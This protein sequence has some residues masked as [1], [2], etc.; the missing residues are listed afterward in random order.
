MALNEVVN[1]FKYYGDPTRSRS[2]FNGSLYIGEPDLDPKIPANQKTVTARQEDGTEVAI[3]QPIA[4]NSG[5]YP[6]FNGSVVMLLV[7]GS[8]SMRLDDSQDNLVYEEALVVASLDSGSGITRVDTVADLRLFEPVTEGQII[9]LL[10][11]TNAGTGGGEFFFDESDASTADNNGTV[12]VTPAGARWKRYNIESLNIEFFGAITGNDSQTAIS[13][14]VDEADV[15]GLPVLIPTG[16]FIKT[17]NKTLPSGVKMIGSEGSFLESDSF[18]VFNLEADCGIDGVGFTNTENVLICLQPL[19]DN[20]TVSRCDFSGGSQIVLV[21]TADFVTVDGCTF[22]GCGFQI[23]QRIGFTSNFGTVSNCTSID[24]V[25]DFVELNSEDANPS[26]NWTV[27]GNRV[28]N[29]GPSGEIATESR[30]LGSTAT[31]NLIISNNIIENTSGDSMIHLEGTSRNT[32]IDG[33]VFVNPHGA[34]GSLI[35]VV[36][37][38]DIPQLLNF[39]NNSVQLN[40]SYVDFTGES[41]TLIYGQGGDAVDWNVSGNTFV[42]DSA[43][44]KTVINLGSSENI[45]FK[46]NRIEGFDTCVVLGTGNFNIAN[47]E[48]NFFS[49]NTTTCISAGGNGDPYVVNITNNEFVDSVEVFIG[50]DNELINSLNTN[51]IGD[52][53][54]I[55]EARVIGDFGNNSLVFNN[56]LIDSGTTSASDTFTALDSVQTKLFT[57]EGSNAFK[58]YLVKVKSALGTIGNGSSTAKVVLVNVNSPL[59]V[60]IVELSSSSSGLT[61]P[62]ILSMDGLTLT[63][64]PSE[65]MVTRLQFLNT[66]TTVHAI[67]EPV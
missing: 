65:D 24:C 18:P 59:D 29:V 32:I 58:S 31:T 14:A 67:D 12:I 63:T 23:I 51:V 66:F 53:T 3:S 40:A 41:S 36:G 57:A 54:N 5:G 20:V 50:N 34:F 13:D 43:S 33:N 55:D 22:T 1:P 2:I 8:Y 62:F 11:H 39:T 45:N 16:S 26:R 38:A 9:E 64:T 60:D 48:G 19:G 25:N 37:T 49:N 46:D 42:N 27:T 28:K 61:A 44:V 7:D 17:G 6:T 56:T 4:T 10:G 52:A 35:F 15:S 21:N 47:V 30:F